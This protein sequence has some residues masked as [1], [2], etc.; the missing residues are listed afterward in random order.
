MLAA[1][2][3]A[4][5]HANLLS[6]NPAAGS[7]V[8][9]APQRVLLRFD[10]PVKPVSGGTGVVDAAGRTVLGGPVSSSPKDV[11]V[12][13][14]PLRPSLPA[15]DYTVRWKIVSTDGHLISGVLAFGVGLGR[16]PPQAQTTQSSAVDWPFLTARFVYF[17][18]L[19]L[20][21]GGAVFRLAVSRPMLD[22]LPAQRRPMASLREGHRATQL[23]LLS[24]VLMLGGGWVA[25]T[26]QGAEVAGVS[27]WA[28]FD[29]RGPVA[30][31]LQ[32]T[33]F[34]REFGRGIDL[35]AGFVVIAA[36]AFAVARRSPRAAMALALPAAALGVWTVIVPGLSG[37]AG[38]A[39]RGWL[40]VAVDAAHVAGSAIW[41]GGLA[42]LVWV[43]PHTTRGLAGEEQA[44]ARLAAVKRFSTIALACVTVIGLTGGARALW[45]V[46]SIPQIW[47][48]GYGRTLIVKTALFALVIALGY[49]NRRGL[50]RFTAVRRRATAEIA[51]LAGV[52]AAVALLTN[53]PPANTPS[54]SLSAPAPPAGG[55]AVLN[56]GGGGR[57]WL[58]PG[59]AGP[60]NVA[61]RLASSRA[62]AA[63]IV[64]QPA[65]GAGYQVTL[66]RVGNT[67]LGLLPHLPPGPAVTQITAGVQVAGATLAIGPARRAPV[68]PPAPAGDG[69]VAAEEAGTIAVG[70]QRIGSRNA[71]VT[72]IS[73]AGA[74]ITDAAVTVAGLPALP[75]ARVPACYEAPVPPGAARLTVRVTRPGQPPVAA[76]VA[77]PSSDAPSGDGLLARST[78]AFQALHSLRV[79]NVLASSP[80]QSVTTTF[81][82]QAPNRLSIDVH[83]GV[84]SRIIGG[85]RYDRT[86]SGGWKKTATPVSREP[87]AWWAPHATAVHIASRH[88]STVLL[89]LVLPT[90]PTFFRLWIDTRTDLVTRLR[91]I[92]TA[93]FMSER[94]L[95]FNSAPP[96]TAPN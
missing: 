95:D 78:R 55:A 41:I 40:T 31:A 52:V 32:A 63:R 58:W 2:A 69:P 79:L 89:T 3:D 26:R 50:D 68:A 51:V 23:L 72:L 15:G 19:M 42:Q 30:S 9:T 59:A 65:T 94:E 57:L 77:L 73:P 66:H 33:R 64:V 13:E 17:A 44:A 1:P 83:G 96:V 54:Y 81:L 12:L 24:A 7:E 14:I 45:E 85:V 88:G 25:L 6:S 92:T 47:S 22:G 82:V 16:P 53:L 35:T 39:G 61:V 49:R 43:V 56:L 29:H 37:H 8:A 20:L 36:A 67:Y 74:G 93:H 62:P 34:G 86:D 76:H 71:R 90:G 80:T 84:Q 18:G 70:L 5:A 11:R 38:D 75:C 46:G 60:N 91:M 48:T 10:Q 87:E 28:A 27:F 4:Q 21:V